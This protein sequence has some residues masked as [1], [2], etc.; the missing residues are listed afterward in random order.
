MADK[1]RYTIFRTKWGFFGLAAS[2]HGLLRTHLPLPDSKKVKSRLLKDLSEAR[3]DQSLLKPLQKQIIAYFR[4]KFVDFAT[5]PTDLDGLP[6]FTRDVLATCRKT[7]PGH[8]LTYSQLAAKLGKPRAA[9]AVGNALAK[10]PIPLI[11]PCHRV[12]RTDGSLGG[13]SAPGGTKTKRKLLDLE[14]QVQDA[15]KTT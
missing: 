10:N 1:T 13:F 15:C 3:P 12:L 11:I 2:E 6:P 5:A 7:P 8:T 14:R 9:R 4:G